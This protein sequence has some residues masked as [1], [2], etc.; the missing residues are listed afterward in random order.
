MKTKIRQ[1][2]FS[3][4]GNILGLIDAAQLQ[5]RSTDAVMIPGGVLT[6]HFG[7]LRRCAATASEFRRCNQISPTLL[8]LLTQQVG[9]ASKS[10]NALR[11]FMLLSWWCPLGQSKG[12]LPAREDIIMDRLIPI[13][14][15]LSSHW[16][17]PLRIH[18]WIQ[19]LKR[20]NA[21]TNV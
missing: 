6:P 12:H 19:S 2:S 1:T 14:T 18:Q 5:R 8:S 20:W 21:L 9:M 10:S 13:L 11:T 16:T 4:R 15:H 7:I 3:P 17:V